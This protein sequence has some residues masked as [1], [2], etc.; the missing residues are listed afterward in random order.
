MDTNPPSDPAEYVKWALNK[1]GCGYQVLAMT[2]CSAAWFYTSAQTYWTSFLND[3]VIEEFFADNDSLYTWTGTAFW[4]GYMA[5]VAATAYV[6]DKFGRMKTTMVSLF[7]MMGGAALCTYATSGVMYAA[8]RITV[9]VGIGGFGLSAFT[10]G[11]ESLG[12]SVR[13]GMM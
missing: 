4:L 13:P 1:S 10:W 8:G 6:S 5:G 12:D 7:I 9:G 2:F 3:Q 11:T